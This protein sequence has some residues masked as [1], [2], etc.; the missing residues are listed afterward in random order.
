MTQAARLHFGLDMAHMPTPHRAH[1]EPPWR[2]DRLA[3]INR[4][5]KMPL[6]ADAVRGIDMNF[7]WGGHRAW[8]IHWAR[9]I[10]NNYRFVIDLQTGKVRRMTLRELH[11]PVHQWSDGA[12]RWRRGPHKGSARPHTYAEVVAYAMLKGVLV[13]AELKSPQFGTAEAA[14]Y[15]VR[16]ARE[17]N[18]PAWFMAL[19]HMRGAR[20]KAEAI[21]AAGGQFALIF[22]R[23]RPVKPND[24]AAWSQHVSAIWGR[25]RWSHG[26]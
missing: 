26:S 18:H 14:Q 13:C 15:L 9:P 12:L 24:W 5:A 10:M 20:R 7:Q 25:A 23:F 8:N 3:A 11:R 1:F 2:G 21:A 22:G 16:S 19:Q 6:G 4:V 17:A